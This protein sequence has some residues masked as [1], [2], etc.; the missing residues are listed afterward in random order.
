M[1]TNPRRAG[2]DLGLDRGGAGVVQPAGALGDDSC[3]RQVDVP[4]GQRRGGARQPP[5]QVQGKAEQGPRG[6]AGQGE[7]GGDLVRDELAELRGEASGGGPRARGA[8]AVSGTAAG[9]LRGGGEF[10]GR[11]P[12][13]LAAVRPQHAD[14]LIIAEQA[15]AVLAGTAREGRQHRPGRQR[16]Q[17]AP[18]REPGPAAGP[19]PGQEPRRD[20]PRHQARSGG[21]SLRDERPGRQVRQIRRRTAVRVRPVPG[22]L[23]YRRHLAAGVQGGKRRIQQGL[24]RRIRQG[25]LRRIRQGPLRRIRHGPLCGIRQHCVVPEGTGI[26][27]HSLPRRRAPDRPAGIPVPGTAV[28][29]RH[30]RHGVVGGR[31]WIR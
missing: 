1:S 26:A 6:P 9:Q 7:G 2:Q 17:R 25:L 18:V 19:V 20:H 30:G 15:Q 27:Q 5:C 21:V 16:V 28:L 29:P 4:G 23:F 10:P 3:S 24:L 8:P 22:L 13:P 14:Q 11:R 31:C 12:G